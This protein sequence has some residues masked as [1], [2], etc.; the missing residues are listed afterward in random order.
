MN[1]S[2]RN[3]LGLTGVGAA[4]FVLASPLKNLYANLATGQPIASKKFGDLIP[5]PQGVIDLPE[6]FKYHIL[7]SVGTQMNDGNLVPDNHD[8]MAAFPGAN[9]TTILVRNHELSPVQTANTINAD[10]PKYDSLSPGGTTTVIIDRDR[11]LQKHF[12]SLSGTNRNCGGGATPWNSWISCE[13][14]IATPYPPPGYTLAD[15]LPYWGKVER[16]H[17]YNF[18]VSAR[19][20]VS[21]P[22]P[23]VAMGRFRHEAIAVDTTT[24]YIYQTEDQLDSCIYRF[25]PS[26]R[27]NLQTGGTLEALVIK[28][29]SQIDTSVNFPLNKT[30]PVEWVKLEDV[31]PQHDT[32]RYEAQSKGAALFKRGEGICHGN[33]SIYWTC[34]NGGRA[35][36]GQ[37]FRYD[38]AKEEIEL[39]AESPTSEVLDYPDNLIL[40]PFGDLIVCEDGA[41]EQFLVGITPQGQYYRLARNAFNNSEFAGVCFAPDGKTMFVNIYK[42]GM[43][44]AIWGF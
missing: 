10:V 22:I 17:G 30:Y 16:K 43:T 19:G 27:Q 15:V 33:G 35:G 42:P 8:G 28:D 25:R 37:I 41:G 26:D 31:D 2:R 9:G 36:V 32:L 4:I 1:L 13:E 44:L 11:H 18:E 23:L 12:I 34:T 20:Q 29:F 3:F 21:K 39:F 24:G 6:G 40:S 14:D 7:S 38:L 5:D